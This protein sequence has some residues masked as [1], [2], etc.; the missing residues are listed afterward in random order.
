[1][2]SFSGLRARVSLVRVKLIIVINVFFLTPIGMGLGG[3]WSKF[4]YNPEKSLNNLLL[5]VFLEIGGE[6]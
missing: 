3:N 4:G 6:N 2:Q 5:T 1:L